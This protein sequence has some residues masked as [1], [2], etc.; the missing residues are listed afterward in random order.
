MADFRPK[1]I[2]QTHKTL[3]DGTRRTYWYHRA[4]RQRLPGEP[5][6]EEFMAAYVKAETSIKSTD[7]NE[8]TLKGLI[9]RYVTSP[10]FEDLR[11]RTR[12]DYGRM[13][14]KIEDAF[15]DLPVDAL[16][17]PRIRM[18][19]KD[20]RDKLGKSSRRQA[21]YALS[22]LS[23]ILNWSVDRGFI[24]HNYALRPGKLYG[25]NRAD[26][27]WSEE[28]INAFLAYATPALRLALILAR[29]TGQRQGDLLRLTWSAY[30]GEWIRLTQSKTGKHVEIYVSDELKAELEATK[31]K[32]R[33]A[34]TILTRSDGQPW[35]EDHFR[36]EWRRVTLAANLDGLRFNDL[37]GTLV[38]RLAEAGCEIPEICSITGHSLKSAHT[39]LE[40]YWS[41]TGKQSSAA[42][43][44]LEAARKTIS[45]NQTAN[46]SKLGRSDN[47]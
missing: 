32:Q 6:S 43:H 10:E 42:I 24:H 22:V 41:A 39:I 11:E 46:R 36:H 40:A 16:N 45:A 2:F 29:D 19:F 35:K 17:D 13:I 20:W 14:R 31:A 21:D 47:A 5:G 12:K 25:V 33:G 44:K 18:D 27:V 9:Q 1:G 3:A 7:R 38:I 15:G 34:V 26:K 23:I 4:S 28:Q 37:R 8:G 30:D